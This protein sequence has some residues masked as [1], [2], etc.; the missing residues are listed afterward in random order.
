MKFEMF[1]SIDLRTEIN[2]WLADHPDADIKF[3]SQAVVT[4]TSKVNELVISLFY[5]E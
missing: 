4:T 3:V 2:D 5:E 1:S